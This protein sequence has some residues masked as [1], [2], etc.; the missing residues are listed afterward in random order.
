MDVIIS[1]EWVDTQKS[2]ILVTGFF[3]DERPLKGASGLIDWRMNG[4]LSRLIIEKRLSGCWNEKILIP[5]QGRLS[6]KLVLLIGL[7]SIKEY[8]YLH[9]RE[10]FPQIIEIL[11]RLN[12]SS[13]CISLP[14]DDRYNVD[15]GK[16]VEVILEVIGDS[17]NLKMDQINEEWINNLRLFFAEGRDHFSEIL[18]GVKTA[19]AFLEDWLKIKIFIPSESP[20]PI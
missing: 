5:S 20:D 14:Y 1:Q 6:S 4:R 9:I 12:M 3:Q 19:K 8:S 16:L 15:C 17:L 11:R 13:I 2:D 18:L 7:G 10:I